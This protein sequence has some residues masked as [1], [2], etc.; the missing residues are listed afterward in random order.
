MIDIWDLPNH[1]VYQQS[2]NSRPNPGARN[3]IPVPNRDKL[4]SRARQRLIM[5]VAAGLHDPSPEELISDM[6]DQEAWSEFN[7]IEKLGKRAVRDL[8]GY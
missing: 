5:E 6:T 2:Q 7:R 1:P 8:F 3:P 4:V